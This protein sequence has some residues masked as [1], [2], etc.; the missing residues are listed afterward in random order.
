MSDLSE[1]AVVILNWNGEDF[2]KKFLPSVIANSGNATIIVADNLSTDN[3]VTFLRNNFPQV[4]IIQNSSNGGFAKGYND[5][6]KNL[7]VV[8]QVELNF[9]Y[10]LL[11]NSDIEVTPN[12][13]SPMHDLLE[14]NENIAACQPKILSYSDNSKFEHAGASGGFLDADY[15]PFCRGRIFSET[16]IDNGQYDNSTEIFWASGAAMFIRSKIF[17]QVGGFD[18]KFFAHMEEIDMCWRIKRL[19]YSFYVVPQ[20]TVYHVGGGTLSYM[21]PR[22]TYLNFRNN[23]FMLI[24]NHRGILLFKIIKRMLLDTIGAIRF[25]TIGEFKNFFMVIKAHGSMYKNLPTLLKQRKS[26]K[27]TDT[28]MPLTGIYFGSLLW[29]HFINKIN[30]FSDLNQHLIE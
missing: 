28:N 22:K 19:G 30:K 5:A 29:S 15:Y 16:E 26:L 6:L 7:L 9:K 2:L 24:K 21:S 20:S 4:Q 3:S 18:E 14:Q 1:I 11:L 25:L 23:L 13:L 12:W 10:Y 17:H 27:K 8:S